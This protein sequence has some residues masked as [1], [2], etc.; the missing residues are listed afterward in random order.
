LEL[1]QFHDLV[2][3]CVRLSILLFINVFCIPVVKK[4]PFAV[5]HTVIKYEIIVPYD[6]R[7]KLELDI[8]DLPRMLH[9][10]HTSFSALMPWVT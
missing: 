8:G 7:F 10:Y 9:T 1:S 3:C 6:V 5:M 2:F 4:L